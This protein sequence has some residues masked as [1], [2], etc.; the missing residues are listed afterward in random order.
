MEFD[1]WGVSRFT[2][3]HPMQGLRR[4]EE[5]GVHAG[6]PQRRRPGR[7]R[8][9]ADDVWWWIRGGK[10]WK[11]AFTNL[12]EWCR[13]PL[14]KVFNFTGSGRDHAVPT[15]PLRESLYCGSKATPSQP[16][17]VDGFLW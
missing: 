13:V 4:P 7:E 3:K 5:W 14:V 15:G 6:T 1:G 2:S 11:A 17:G 12:P 16:W 10:G 8:N 9:A